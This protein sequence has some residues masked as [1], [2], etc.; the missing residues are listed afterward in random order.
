MQIDE[1]RHF[2]RDIRLVLLVA[3][4]VTSTGVFALLQNLSHVLFMRSRATVDSLAR[5]LA[6]YR[7]SKEEQRR[8]VEEFVADCSVGQWGYWTL[9]VQTGEFTRPAEAQSDKSAASDAGGIEQYEKAAR[10]YI[11][12]FCPQKEKALAIFRF[13]VRKIP[14][15]T[16]SSSDLTLKLWDKKEGKERTLSLVDYVHCV[17]TQGQKPSKD[18]M[19]LHRYIS[20]HA[21]VPECFFSNDLLKRKPVNS[22]VKS[23]NA[24][25]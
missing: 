13:I 16:L 14:L 11:G 9:D 4:S 24:N 23:S 3:H 15:A 6:Q 8:M 22:K 1:G 19:A 7:F 21:E 17:T 2:H 20:A 12:L 18:V 10:E 25:K 5:V